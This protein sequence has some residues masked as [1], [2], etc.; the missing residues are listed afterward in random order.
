MISVQVLA[1]SFGRME[2]IT[3][4]N[5]LMEK[6]MEMATGIPKRA[7]TTWENGGMEK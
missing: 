1:N 3:R 5:G 2:S 4:E 7:K 6:R